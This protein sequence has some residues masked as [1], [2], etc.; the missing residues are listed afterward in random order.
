M[1]T[2]FVLIGVIGREESAFPVD[3]Q[4]QIPRFAGDDNSKASSLY[5]ASLIGHSQRHSLQR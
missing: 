4:K 2:A 1:S 5:C 3:R